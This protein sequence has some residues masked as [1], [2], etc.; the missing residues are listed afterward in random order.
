MASGFSDKTPPA[1]NR[2]TDVYAKWKRQFELWQAI[3]DV[4]KAKQGV[5][6]VL[7]LDAVT[8]EEVLE[9]MTNDDI[10]KDGVKTILGHLD[11]KF[12]V[13]KVTSAYETYEEFERYRRGEKA[14][15]DEHCNE[16]EKRVSKVK[17]KGTQLSTEVLAYRLLKSAN[18]DEGQ[19]Q[20][21]KAT[22]GEISYENM[23]KQF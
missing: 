19:E 4:A 13:D 1:F 20:L 10:K 21:V 18:L 16:F 17:A 11:K 3:T 9:L 6:L 14:S 8:Q 5:L 7:R 23:A 12:E 2:T 22:I 15:I